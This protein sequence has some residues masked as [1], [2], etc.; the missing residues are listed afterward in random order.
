MPGVIEDAVEDVV[1][2]DTV[3]ESDVPVTVA[4]LSGK[5]FGLL[6]RAAAL[7]DP[8]ECTE[9]GHTFRQLPGRQPRLD[10]SRDRSFDLVQ[11]TVQRAHAECRRMKNEV[12]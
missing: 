12:A 6:L 1:E 7:T 10:Q 11:G 3:G 9:I 4:A 8:R 2:V 5:P